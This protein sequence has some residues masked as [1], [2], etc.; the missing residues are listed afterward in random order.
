MHEKIELKLDDLAVEL[1]KKVLEKYSLKP[2][3][4]VIILEVLIRNQIDLSTVISKC[5]Y[6]YIKILLCIVLT[7]LKETPSW[8][9]SLLSNF[10][11]DKSSY[12]LRGTAYS[13]LS[14]LNREKY[15]H[16]MLSVISQEENPYVIER[17]LNCLIIIQSNEAKMS[18]LE[19]VKRNFKGSINEMINTT[20]KW[21]DP[22]L[23]KLVKNQLKK[24]DIVNTSDLYIILEFIVIICPDDFEELLLKFFSKDKALLMHQLLLSSLDEMNKAATKRGYLAFDHQLAIDD[25]IKNLEIDWLRE[26]LQEAVKERRMGTTE[27]GPLTTLKDVDYWLTQGDPSKKYQRIQ[28]LLSKKHIR[29]GGYQSWLVRDEKTNKNFVLEAVEE[30]L[31]KEHKV[32]GN[33]VTQEDIKEQLESN[34]L[35]TLSDCFYDDEE[36]KKNYWF[37][38]VIPD[39]YDILYNVYKEQKIRFDEQEVLNMVSSLFNQAE[40]IKQHIGVEPVVNPYTVIL[41]EGNQVRLINL[42]FGIPRKLYVST[43]NEC[44]ADTSD[45]TNSLFNG[46]LSYELISSKCPIEIYEKLRLK[47][48]GT[49]ELVSDNLPGATVSLHFA[50]ILDHLCY[51][52]NPERR[53]RSLSTLK[54]DIA[55]SRKFRNYFQ[56]I[57]MVNLLRDDKYWSEVFDV[58]N[59]RVARFVKLP[60]KIHDSIHENT[61]QVFNLIVHCVTKAVNSRNSSRL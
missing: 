6:P 15:P 11:K 28:N 35:S 61:L 38:Y 25:R 50:W 22:M 39:G 56:D 26:T 21:G 31:L 2:H 41:G 27:L 54:K 20:I 19:L 36:G 60:H 4:L 49:H 48:E 5:R 45:T 13:T 44:I 33:G 51:P 29:Q 58:L 3:H 32:I 23:D 40:C 53:Y 9:E 55:C 24:I 42:F 17:A 16:T 37:K 34:K 18:F 12:I 30:G 46:L 7:T 8:A 10:I 52:T 57:K 43:D 59:L 47:R 14:K 1:S